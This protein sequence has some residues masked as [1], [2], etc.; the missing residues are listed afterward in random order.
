MYSTRPRAMFHGPDRPSPLT[1]PAALSVYDVERPL[2]DV[3]VH[4]THV[5][6]ED[7]NRQQLSAAEERQAEDGDRS[8]C[9]C[10]IQEPLTS[11]QRTTDDH[12]GSD[13]E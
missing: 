5:L 8:G 3:A 2:Q 11:Q 6:A 10:R 1:A 13:A 4:S 7:S 9:H 12:R